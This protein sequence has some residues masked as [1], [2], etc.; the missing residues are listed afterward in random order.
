[1]S[2]EAM[3]IVLHHS[4]ARGSD[5]VVL[6]GVANHEGDGGAWPAVATLAKYANLSIR[7]TQEA[8]RRLEL[9]GE[10]ATLRNG[11]GLA[12]TPEYL[13]PNQYR[14]RLVCP[15]ECD[16]TAQHRTEAV[17][18]TGCGEP[19]GIRCGGPHHPGAVHRTRT[20]L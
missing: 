9:A 8:L 17:A 20:I 15:P 6:I 2:V 3:A 12:S 13:R 18:R 1:M 19:Q 14:V 10:L 7:A 16:R 4:Q 11:G 5:K